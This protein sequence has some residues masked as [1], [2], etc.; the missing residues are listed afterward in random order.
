MKCLVVRVSLGT[1]PKTTPPCESAAF[2]ALYSAS[3]SLNANLPRIYWLLVTNE[4]SQDSACL[5]ITLTICSLFCIQIYRVPVSVSQQQP[6]PL[7]ANL[8]H[9]QFWHM[10]ANVMMLIIRT[11][12]VTNSVNTMQILKQLNWLLK[13]KAR[14]YSSIHPPL[15]ETILA[16]I[17][18]NPPETHVFD[19]FRHAKFMT[20]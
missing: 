15:R 10:N 18:A 7:C 20:V 4:R 8:F 19:L 13:L 16:I 9:A 2:C 6:P 17:P 14:I 12:V 11:I 3:I 5:C 1:R